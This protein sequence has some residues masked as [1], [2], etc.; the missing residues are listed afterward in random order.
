MLYRVTPA[1]PRQSQLRSGP[2]QAI[3][4]LPQAI[5]HHHHVHFHGLDAADV[6]NIIRQQDEGR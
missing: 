6:A 2:R 3:G 5:E 4:Q 1:P